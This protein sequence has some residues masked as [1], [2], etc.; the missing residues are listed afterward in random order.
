M[1][2]MDGIVNR[3]YGSAVICSVVSAAPSALA[4]A[5]PYSH[6]YKCSGD[7]SMR[8]RWLAARTINDPTSIPQCN[9]D[10]A[11]STISSWKY[12]QPYSA[13]KA[14]RCAAVFNCLAMALLKR[15]SHLCFLRA[16]SL[17]SSSRGYQFS[18]K[19]QWG[20][21]AHPHRL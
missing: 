13:L 19:P 6:Q 16:V 4:L 2:L 17:S 20:P 1:Q 9:V 3:A 10:G 11:Y 21:A 14:L 12:S 7:S 18:T 15:F 8:P 5:G